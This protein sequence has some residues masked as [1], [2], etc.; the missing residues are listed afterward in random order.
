[1]G[2]AL[3]AVG[4]E[5]LIG[6]ILGLII[7]IIGLFFGNIIVF[8]SI[9]LA[10]LAGFLSHGLLHIHPALAIVIGIVTLLGFLLLQRT[11]PGFWI[12][13]ALLSLLWGIIFHQWRMSFPVK[14][15][16]GPMWYWR[17]GRLR[18]CAAPAG[19]KPDGILRQRNG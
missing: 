10:V 17:L 3:L 13:G 7:T 8:D 9:A 14:I 5:L 1:M 4:I 16:Y 19:A 11:R 6:I 18:F 12:I 2:T 15:W